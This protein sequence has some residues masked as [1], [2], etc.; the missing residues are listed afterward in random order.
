[1]ARVR[2][3]VTTTFGLTAAAPIA[4]DRV[5]AFTR[6]VEAFR[7]ELGRFAY[8]L[9]GS[10]AG[11]DDLVAEACAR[12][13]PH[14]KRGRI[15]NLPA[16]L[17]RSIVNLSN[18]RLRRLRLER[19]E[20]ESRRIDWRA[21]ELSSRERGFEQVDARDDLWRAIWRL[22]PDQRAVIVLRPAEDRSEEET[23]A[24]LGISVGTVKSR[25][26]RGLS[27]LRKQLALPTPKDSP[28]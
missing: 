7:I 26:A 9:V 28:Q 6:D 14:Y 18:G 2:R 19:R 8:L 12:A 21:P 27:T 24:L 15:D 11:A 25:L 22:P 17:R 5:S 10:S 3:S 20:V 23:A 1:V 16:Y 4:V 13:W